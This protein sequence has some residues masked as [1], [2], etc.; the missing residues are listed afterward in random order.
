MFLSTSE[1]WLSAGVSLVADQTLYR[2]VSEPDF[3]RLASLADAVNVLVRTPAARERFEAKMAADPRN[4]TGSL[5]ALMVRWDNILDD[6]SE[7]LA[8]GCPV[9]EVDTT[10]M[11]D[12]A[13][14]AA[15]A[16][17]LACP[18]GQ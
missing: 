4:T 12:V 7:P 6:V 9:L 14:L 13:D 8:L 18:A 15:Q 17:D 10:G 1:A 11:A 16:T 2:G 3:S 5:R